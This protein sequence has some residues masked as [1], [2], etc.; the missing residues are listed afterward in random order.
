M[1]SGSLHGPRLALRFEVASP[2]P[3]PALLFGE[4][5]NHRLRRIT[6]A[7]GL[8]ALVSAP[9]LAHGGKY[10]GPG[11]TVPPAPGGGG[12][13]RGATPDGP[14]GGRP[15]TP[16]G[17]GPVL[18]GG[19]PAGGETGRP[20]GPTGVPP[21]GGLTGPRGGA[22][23]E[24]LTT[25]DQWWEFNKDP[26][27]RLRDAVLAGGVSTGDD[28]DF[29]VGST[30][31]PNDNTSLRPSA[32]MIQGE[33][34]PALKKAIDSTDQRDINSSCMVAMAKIG[35]DHPDF[36]L[37]SVFAPRLKKGDQ[38][39]RETAAL[40]LGIAAIAGE[41][42]LELLIGLALDKERGRDASGGEV[43]YRTRSFAAYGLG[44]VANKTTDLAIK[45]KAFEA[46]KTLLDDSKLTNRDIK[47]AAI[48]GMAI[49]NIPTSTD[50]DR[51]L[52]DD[53]LKSL[54]GYYLQKLGASECL[55]QAHV[56][57]AIAKLI[58]RDHKDA[59]R[60]KELFADD[61]QETG[62]FKRAGNEIPESCVLA[63]AKLARPYQD[64]DDKAN[65]DNRYSK[66]LATTSD[67]H[68]DQQTQFFSYLALGLIGGQKN[69]EYLM[70]ALDK[71]KDTEKAWCVLALGVYTHWKLLDD[72]NASANP[73]LVQS[74]MKELK[75]AKNPEL[76]GALAISLGLCRGRAAAEEMRARMENSVAKEE[77]A[78]FLAVGLALMD[79]RAS[80]P[81]LRRLVQ[82]SV[83]RFAF[84]QKAAIALGK[85]GDK[86]VADDLQDLL[87]EK[88]EANT[89]LAKLSALAHAIGFIG[90]HRSVAPLKRML[91]DSAL[92]ELPR[93]FA[94]VALGGVADKEPLPWNS[95]LAVDTNYR[96][97][98]E[99]LSNKST[100]V[101]DIL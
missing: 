19:G 1:E 64:S 50:A 36:T 38:E 79:D 40:A 57:T 61:L 35:V 74:M 69:E 58:T 33:I 47:V 67:K 99:T 93:A 27:I 45:R 6:A 85:L 66:L 65:P 9:L 100:G 71:G 3:V 56:P 75:D 22:L 17:G 83:R 80:V 24:D 77:M 51:A 96:A 26:Y 32:E 59:E 43:D 54:D 8:L 70:K 4:F 44:L 81:T 92:G 53:V 14:G 2:A 15:T 39:I 7:L 10:M 29:P 12:G 88:G 89:N 13:G 73:L 31:R 87:G 62:K 48:N 11:D 72:P 37:R 97:Q 30:V 95:K 23:P 34:L 91:F 49:L 94:A 52:L 90:D 46:L 55:I 78:G 5:M 101:L 28:G 68:I 84:L 86:Q 42:E 25:W 18:P 82:G 16:G 21:A 20:V 98:V 63:L 76:V 41:E 60:Y